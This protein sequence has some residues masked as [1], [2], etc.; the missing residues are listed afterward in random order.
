[1]RRPKLT[2]LLK[3]AASKIAVITLFTV[4]TVASFAT[5]GDGGKR[6]NRSGVTLISKNNYKPGSISLH[7]NYTYRGSTIF[8]A[9]SISSEKKVIR[10][11]YTVTLQKGNTS[12]IVPL[13]KNVVVSRISIGINN[14]LNQR[15]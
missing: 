4:T 2:I 7:S 8:N 12:F 6:T 5:L 11:N 1:M 10:L 14:N 15:N 3:L 9:N 13:K